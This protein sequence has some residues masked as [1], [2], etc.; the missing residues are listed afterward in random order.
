[1][2]D[3][4]P[5]LPGWRV[6]VFDGTEYT[7]A[8]SIVAWRIPSTLDESPMPITVVGDLT[9]WDNEPYCINTG[10][11]VYDKSG[12]HFDALWQWIEWIKEPRSD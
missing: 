4:I 5:A 10:Y 2:S 1:M 3:V 7:M 8:Y 12:K 9:G 6:E 11:E